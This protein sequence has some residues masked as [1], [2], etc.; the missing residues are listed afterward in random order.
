MEVWEGKLSK[1]WLTLFAERLYVG[2]FFVAVALCSGSNVAIAGAT[3]PVGSIA[4]DQTPV[5]EVVT[6]PAPPPDLNPLSASDDELADY[7]YPPRPNELSAPAAYTHWRKLVTVPRVANPV[8]QQ[9]TIYNGPAQHLL[10]GRTL[11]NGIVSATSSNWSGYAVTGASSTFTNN[12]S[13]IF[14]EWVVPVAQQA[15]G[16]CNGLWDYSSQWD[17]FDGFGSDDVLQ[18]GTEADAYCSGSSKA[19]F[20]SSWI[21]WY[22]FSE[23]RVS[24]P[25]AQPGDLMESEVWYTTSAPYGHAY[26]VNYTLQQAQ[27]Y[28]FN[29]PSGT[30]F[31]GNSAEWVEE[32]PGLGKGQLADLTNYVADQFNIDYAYNRISYF[33]PGSSPTGTTTYAIKMSCPPWTPSSSCS[34]TTKLSTPALYG[35]YTL[36]FYD[37]GPAF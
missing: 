7:G 14:A 29:P 33:Y 27:T 32:R 12:N 30:V 9:T 2:V 34:S 16:V 6:Y 35:Q 37:S 5:Q 17:G 11:N 23:T 28:A 4:S 31:V 21:E 8:L 20:Y 3:P 13:V 1:K 25:A 19:T 24:V 22:P 36:W 26:L 10:S 15:F 18:A